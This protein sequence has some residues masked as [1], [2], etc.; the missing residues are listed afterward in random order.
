M[1]EMEV[2]CPSCG[3]RVRIEFPPGA[4]ALMVQCGSCGTQFQAQGA[5]A[6]AP[7]PVQARPV[8]AAPVQAQ[9]P[10]MQGYAPHGAPTAAQ[11][12]RIDVSFGGAATDAG[13][14]RDYSFVLSVGGISVHQFHGRYSELRTRCSGNP[15]GS[16]PSKHP[17]KNFTTNERNVARRGEELKTFFQQ[18]LNAKDEGNV[19]GSAQVHTALG[20]TSQDAIQTFLRIAATRKGAANAH[21]A[22]AAAQAAAIVQQQQAD[23]QHAQE[24]NSLVA[25]SGIAPGQLSTIVFPHQ[26][27]F[28]LRNKFWGW[29]DANITGPGGRPWFKMVR[30][31]ANPWGE[32]FKNCSFAICTMRGEPLMLLQENFRWGGSYEYDLF[33]MDPRTGQPIPVCKIV[34]NWGMNI[35]NVTDQYQV[36]LFPAAAAH[37]SVQCSGRWPNQFTLGLN[38]MGVATVDK[39]W[40]FGDKYHVTIAPNTDLLLFIG[41]ACGI[42]R[43][44]HEV[45]EHNRR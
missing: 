2:D 28:E 3:V 32:M 41:I 22:Q 20:M 23:C 44:H 4:N 7:P 1:S 33:R 21:R 27:R 29:G 31:N 16:F 19:V 25:Y 15:F 42:D 37:G 10:P 14:K 11:S 17:M 43:I 45:E 18:Q 30:Q 38:G 26:Q 6:P 8:Q 35:F 5:P 13:G 39:Q 12:T 36:Q 24:F 34:R 40:G 9:A